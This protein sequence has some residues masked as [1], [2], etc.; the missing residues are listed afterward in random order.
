MF[1]K[2]EESQKE[3]DFFFYDSNI[4]DINLSDSLKMIIG[5]ILSDLSNT[6][7]FI[8]GYP[9]SGKSCAGR[10]YGAKRSFNNRD[11]PQSPI[12]NPHFLFNNF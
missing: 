4:E 10:F 2:Y 9:G 1:T 3:S 7:I 11:N 6:S 5:I 8:Q 12:P